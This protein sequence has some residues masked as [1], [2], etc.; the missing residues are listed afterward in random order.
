MQ[1]G[2]TV[3][4]GGKTNRAKLEFSEEM[5]R[6]LNKVPE[7]I[8]A[9]NE[10]VVDSKSTATINKFLQEHFWFIFSTMYFLLW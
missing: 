8:G 7:L 9:N 4:V 3:V 1:D 5:N 2:S 6:L 10:N